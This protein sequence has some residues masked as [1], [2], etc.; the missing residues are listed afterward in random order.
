MCFYLVVAVISDNGRLQ[1]IVNFGKHE[2]SRPAEKAELV[3]VCFGVDL[4]TSA[5]LRIVSKFSSLRTVFCIAEKLIK[6]SDICA[7]VDFRVDFIR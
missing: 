4:D 2:P 7:S 5:P 6:V 3:D 1:L